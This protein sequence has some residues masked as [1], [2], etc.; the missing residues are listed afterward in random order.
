MIAELRERFSFRV[1]LWGLVAEEFVQI[2]AE[3]WNTLTQQREVLLAN[4]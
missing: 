3:P 1:E 4:E 2:P